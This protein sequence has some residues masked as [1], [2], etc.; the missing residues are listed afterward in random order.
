M[1]NIILLSSPIMKTISLIPSWAQHYEEFWES[2]KIR[3]AWFIKLRY[4][5]VLMLV[6]FLTTTGLLFRISFTPVQF[7]AISSITLSIFLYN[8]VLAR[9][10][11]YIKYSDEGFNPIHFSIIQ[12]VLD[13]YALCLLVYYSGGIESPLF[14]LFIFHMVIGSMIL[15]RLVIYSSACLVILVFSGIVFA[16]YLGLIA[17]HSIAGFLKDPFYNNISYISVILAVFAFV[18]IITV[19][20]ANEIANKLY[21]MEE[22]LLDSLDKLRAVEIEKENYITG[23]V[24]EIKTPIAAVQSYL[25]LILGNYLGPVSPKIEDKLKRTRSRSDEAIQM[26]NNILKI[27]R[28][29]ILDDLGKD[30]LDIKRLVCSA[31]EKLKSQIE[32]KGINFSLIDNRKI[33]R[34]VLGDKFLLEIGISNIISNA[35]KYVDK[36]GKVV[37][38]MA[39]SPNSVEIKVCDNGIGIPSGESE[40]I[41]QE[42][43]R[44]S[45][46]KHKGYE[47]VGLGLTVVKQIITK[48]NGSIIV[49]SPSSLTSENHP[50]T[51]FTITLP[52]INAPS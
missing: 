44:A 15:P 36:C 50:G 23:V 35:I 48:H 24:H 26:I 17:H 28:L 8:I 37:V 46:I 6:A 30:E 1:F 39:D 10:Q 52:T 7:Y 11:K 20:L 21:K 47:G 42:F 29:K 49:Q 31:H 3:N 40:N 18:L 51:C 19:M 16:E 34:K 27:S 14:L 13:L 38:T 25:D 9:L 33:K 43:F 22:N 4:S 41:F 45:N 12:M 2:V 32:T 5:A